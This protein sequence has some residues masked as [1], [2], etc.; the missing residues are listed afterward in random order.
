MPDNNIV[1]NW[2]GYQIDELASW[3]QETSEIMNRAIVADLMGEDPDSLEHLKQIF[4]KI[5]QSHCN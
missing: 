2:A 5:F 1:K 4:G 3:F